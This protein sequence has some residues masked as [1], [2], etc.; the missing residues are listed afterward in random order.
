MSS[1]PTIRDVAK[2]LR[3]GKSTVQRALAGCGSISLQTRQRVI[4]AARELGYQ[5]DPFFSILGS[6]GRQSNHKTLQIAYISRNDLAS[7]SKGRAGVDMYKLAKLQ[8][9]VM[10]YEVERIELNEVRAGKR[11]MDVLYHRGF[12]GVLLGQI[13]SPDHE[14]I[15][16]NT[17]L[18]VVCCGRI[19]P[20]PLHTV[21]PDIIQMVRLAWRNMLRAGYRRIG[22]AFGVHDPPVEDDSDRLGTLVEC[23]HDILRKADRVPVLRARM[24]DS[25]ALLNWLLRYKPEAVL[26]FNVGQYFQL[27]EAGVDMSQFGFAS[28]HTLPGDGQIAGIEEPLSAIPREALNLLDQLIRHRTVGIPEEPLHVGVPGRWI[29]GSSLPQKQ[30]KST[31]Q[32][33]LANRM[34]G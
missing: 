8:G 4:D 1:A 29:E 13:R 7:T 2:Q 16:A 24:G 17:H 33:S 20:L 28:L 3:L 9:E 27:K 14:A 15:L 22:A 23:Q 34:H 11:L 5:R 18:P 6:R 32:A 25:R 31:R 30:R 10:G 19:D 12:V 21:Q 26:S